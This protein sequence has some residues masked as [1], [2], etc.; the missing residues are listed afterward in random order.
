MAGLSRFT[1]GQL[2]RCIDDDWNYDVARALGRVQ[3]P[4]KGARYTVSGIGQ[5][6]GNDIVDRMDIVYLEEMPEG[7]FDAD[8]F[9]PATDS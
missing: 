1:I 4:Q 7:S 9:A 8:A 5:F 3:I 6:P 2:V